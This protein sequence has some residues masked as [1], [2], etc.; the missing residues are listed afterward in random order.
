MERR[1]SKAFASHLTKEDNTVIRQE[2]S[3]QL[4]KVES[5]STSFYLVPSTVNQD[6]APVGI[7]Q[8][9]K[10]TVYSKSKMIPE[11]EGNIRIDFVVEIPKNLQGTCRSVTLQPCIIQ[12]DE[13]IRLQEL[14]IR[15]ALFNK[16]QNR[17]YWQFN[18][19]AAT[20]SDSIALEKAFNRFIKYPYPEHVRVDSII[21]NPASITFHY[22]QQIPTD[23]ISP[24]VKIVMEGSVAGLDGS[25]YKMPVTDTLQYNISSMINFIDTTARHKL[26]IIDKHVVATDRTYLQF[27]AND[28]Q[29]IDTLGDNKLELDKIKSLLERVI[30]LDEF[31]VDS[32]II[33]AAA[34]PEG[35]YHINERIAKERALSV[36]NYMAELYPALEEGLVVQWIAEDWDHL[37]RLIINSEALSNK[38]AIITIIDTEEDADKRERKIQTNYPIDYKYLRSEF[39]PFLRTVDIKCSLRRKDMVKDTIVTREV[40]LNYARGVDFL[41]KRKYGDAISILYEYRD[42]NTVIALM[43][44][45]NN[46]AALEILNKMETTAIHEYLKAILMLRL[47]RRKEG[48]Q[49]FINSCNLDE[50]MQFR[51]KLD[52]EINELI[53]N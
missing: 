45:G 25:S 47:G 6:G 11:R 7:I 1:Q 18:H 22:S 14:V 35:H 16:V 13:F 21:N 50:N 23:G 43:S 30:E 44:M 37:R 12:G 39:Y 42:R 48:F 2:L 51:A 28:S 4:W 9:E 32:I 17:N 10:I 31:H 40:D 38:E 3:E 46:E 24:N 34:S 52:P 15:G 5:D 33:T 19:F 29:L 27:Y 41:R 8:M 20:K 36:R 26:R 49:C 53:T